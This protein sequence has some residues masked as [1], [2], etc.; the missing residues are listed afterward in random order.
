M[1]LY[2][3][4]QIGDF[5]AV[6]TS[7]NA[8]YRRNLGHDS[9]EG[10]ATAIVGHIGSVC[11]TGISREYLHRNCKKASRETVPGEWLRAIGI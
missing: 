6:G 3:R 11:K 4:E 8:Y 2:F 1:T 10:R 9:F 5:L 7:S